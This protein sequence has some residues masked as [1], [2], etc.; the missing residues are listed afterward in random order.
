MKGELPSDRAIELATEARDLIRD[1]AQAAGVG[2]VVLT[3]DVAKLKEGTLAI[4][5]STHLP[6]WLAAAVPELLREASESET[7]EPQ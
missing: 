4:C 3:F 5:Q 2:V 6:R 7:V 1:R